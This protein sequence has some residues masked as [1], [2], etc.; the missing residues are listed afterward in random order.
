MSEG[1]S[2]GPAGTSTSPER[3]VGG[4]MS[5]S[6]SGAPGGTPGAGRTPGAGGAG[7]GGGAAG[8]NQVL[9]SPGMNASITL[10]LDVKEDVLLLPTTA[11]RRQGRA[12]FV[13]KLKDDGTFEQV[14][15]TTNGSDSTNT[16][17]ATG[18]NEGDAVII[19]QR[20]GAPK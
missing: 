3:R 8:A 19:D 4:S 18:L 5:T 15:V 1:L 6:G 13:Y 11:V 12:S 14:T 2:V 16:A 20:S 9:P 17:I 10:V 7:S